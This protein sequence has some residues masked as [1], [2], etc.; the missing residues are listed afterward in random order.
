MH[1][2]GHHKLIDLLGLIRDKKI[3]QVNAMKIM[4]KVLDGD[5]RLPCDISDN[6]GFTGAVK[7]SEELLAM[8]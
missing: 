6:M 4:K 3:T 2:F 5:T 8:V 7:Q 1:T